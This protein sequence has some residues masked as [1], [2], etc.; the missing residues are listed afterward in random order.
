MSAH[1]PSRTSLT[2]ANGAGFDLLN[3]GAEA[4][5]FD[6]I[7]EHLAKANRYCG[8][9]PMVIYSVSEHSCR[10]ALAAFK[11]T[12]D[13]ILSKYFL[14]HDMKEAFLGDDTT[15]KKRA[16]AAIIESFGALASTVDSAFAA[17]EDGIDAAI[18]ARAGLPWPPSPEMQDAIKHWDRVMLAT[19]WRDLMCCE[20]PY[21]FGK[22]PLPERIIPLQWWET[23]FGWMMN[24][25]EEYG[26]GAASV[27][28]AKAEH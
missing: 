1:D 3:P 15:P 13:R 28:G 12:G 19:E 21:D 26:I 25:C 7:A 16:L 27:V 6:V 9:T 17:L 24:L 8:A 11:A 5:D 14:C 23:S 2:L 18:H 4:I 10:G 20:P 22:E